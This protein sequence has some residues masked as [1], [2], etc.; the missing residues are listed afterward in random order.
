M[1]RSE[2]FDDDQKDA[3]ELGAGHTVTALYEVMEAGGRDPGK[4]P[5]L[6]YQETLIKQSA[7]LSDELLTLKLRYKNPKQDQSQLLSVPV[8][9][10]H[11]KLTNTSNNFRFSASVAGF[12]LMLRESQYKGDL[13]YNE[14]LKMA[15]NAVG[16][17]K[18]GYRSEFI[19]LVEKAKL[20][21]DSGS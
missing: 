9:D 14:I 4:S 7:H 3:G 11:L 17:D 13:T 10:K 12:G 15:Q 19:Q 8:K 5:D 6:K 1:L 2:D 16:S 20:L 18:E 21:K